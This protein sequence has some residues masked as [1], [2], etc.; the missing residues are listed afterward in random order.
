MAVVYWVLQPKKFLFDEYT[1]N[2]ALVQSIL[3]PTL[4]TGSNSL[5]TSTGDVASGFMSLSANGKFL[6]IPGINTP[7]GATTSNTGI[8][9]GLLDF[10][11]EVNTSTVV[12]DVSEN[13]RKA[14]SAISDDGTRIWFGGHR[15][16]RTTTVGSGT[17]VLVSNPRSLAA[18]SIDNNQLYASYTNSS[19][20]PK[21]G[22]VG[23]GLPTVTGQSVTDL[24]GLPSN[25]TGSGQFAFADLDPTV[26]GVDVLYL[27][28]ASY[29]NTSTVNGIRK[30]S[31]VSGAWVDNG[32]I[33]SGGNI[34]T[35]GLAIQVSGSSVT[36]F[37]TRSNNSGI[38]GQEIVRLTDNSGYNATITGS[39][40]VIATVA[41]P[42]T[43][44]YRGLA[45]VPQPAPFT[46]GNMVVYRVGDGN[47]TLGSTATKVYLDEYT[48]AGGLVQS[49]LMPAVSSGSNS[50]LTA[51][52]GESALGYMNL[53]AD[54]KYLTVPG[55]NVPL[56]ST[57][58][59]TAN[60]IGIVDFKG[61][62]NTST[63]VTDAPENGRKAN[64][65]ISLDGNDIWFGGHR[66][67]RYTK[68]GASNSVLVAAP[69]SLA[70]LKIADNQL[71]AAYVNSS[72]APKLG[73][74][75]TGLPATSGQ[76]VADLPG[77][78]GN[79][80]TAA[81]FAF[82][83]LNP[84]IPSVD[85]IYLAD[86][87]FSAN[88]VTGIRKFSLVGGSWVDNGAVGGNVANAFYQGLAIR[89]SGNTVTIF[90]TKAN[91]NGVAGQEIVNL[92]DNSGYNATLTG[93]P[94]VLVSVASPNTKAFRGIAKVPVGC[95]PITELRVPEISATQ[96]NAVWNPPVNGTN[97]YE[98]AL[99]TS[100]M[101]PTSGAATTS[102]AAG[103][104]GLT[105][106]TTY[107]LHVRSVCSASNVSEWSTVSFVTGCQS[108]VAPFV[109]VLIS[110]SGQVKI[111]WNKVFDAADY[112]YA[113][114]KSSTAPANGTSTVDTSV[115]MFGLNSVTEY[116]VHIRSRCGGGAVSPWITKAFKTT[117]FVPQPAAVVLGKNGTVKWNSISNATNYQ[118]ALTYNSAKPVSGT[119]TSD[120]SYSLNNM[121]EGGFYYFHVRSVCSNGAVSEWSSV[122]VKTQGLQ[123][124]PN[125]VSDNLQI[126]LNGIN[127]SSAQ[128]T[129]GD[130]MGRVIT[131]IK[132]NNNMDTINTRGWAPGIYLVRYDDGKNK[133]SVRIVKQ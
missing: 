121:N 18:F 44:G 17:S 33:G 38:A 60:V 131:R 56:G 41:T 89:V 71:Y 112:E 133:Y 22:R 54:G 26:P 52:G 16:V 74:I 80:S 51:M 63:V 24:P 7:L 59:P 64:T 27:A 82:A 5:L 3:M 53:S 108:P 12:T 48:T 37:A 76:P 31:L 111:K 58:S 110:D 13:G 103:I 39:L 65:A 113:V 90:A 86:A 11:G 9:I 100:F 25:I 81:Q 67:L 91:S 126:Q 78:P 79:I 130:A 124:Y 117:C 88:A 40:T 104:T 19:F 129:I 77:L 120:T 43:M 96:A 66:V 1:P 98:Y 94:T 49:L 70:D 45:L 29:S 62:V 32:S 68:L 72:F 97:G 20:A 55:L 2:G 8:V 128:I 122:P 42:G 36:V 50:L 30:F 83:D 10:N 106:A 93:T 15:V 92:V 115:N 6:V 69:R 47:S 132:L 114:T 125:P 101:P 4:T 21:V 109:N 107:Y 57:A 84:A 119:S 99:T 61:T 46:P 87:S 118:Y 116:Y 75:G 102:A 127:A 123:A 14:N 95:L 23:T 85:V 105:N 28:D 73:K 35:Q 34:L